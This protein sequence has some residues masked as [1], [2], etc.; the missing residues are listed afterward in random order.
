MQ[1]KISDVWEKKTA[2]DIDWSSIAYNI[3]VK[4]YS[5]RINDNINRS[6]DS[7]VD[8]FTHEEYM[9]TRETR[10][11]KKCFIIWIIEIWTKVGKETISLISHLDI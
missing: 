10:P 1:G 2:R 3:V 9:L 6:V 5:L 4:D 7:G 8:E 11:W